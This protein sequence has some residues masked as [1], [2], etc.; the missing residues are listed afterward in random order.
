VTETLTL[1]DHLEKF[2]K[3]INGKWKEPSDIKRGIDLKVKLLKYYHRQPYEGDD[4][5]LLELFNMY[6]LGEYD[7]KFDPARSNLMTY[8]T[9]FIDSHLNKMLLDRNKRELW[10]KGE[11]EI[12]LNGFKKK[13]RYKSCDIYEKNFRE[14][15]QDH[16]RDLCVNN[17]ETPETI[18]EKNEKIKLFW[19][20]AKNK[21]RIAEAKMIMEKKDYETV[22]RQTGLPVDTIRKRIARLI[23]CF[24]KYYEEL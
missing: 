14:S 17:I 22:S 13:I 23:D 10:E 6:L 20:F 5:V 16:D 21:N 12:D 24:N 1:N 2:E 4:F 18:L 7:Q 11:R 9:V 15:F 8:V 3:V 19:K